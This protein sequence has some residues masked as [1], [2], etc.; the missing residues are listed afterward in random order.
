[1]KVRILEGPDPRQQRHVLSLKRSRVVTQRTGRLAVPNPGLP[2]TFPR[3]VLLAVAGLSPQVVTET[4][5]ALSQK[6]TPAFVPTEVHLFTTAEGAE[7][8][9]L[10]LL[11]DHPGWFASLRKDYGLPE[12]YFSE[13]TVH[14]L[15]TLSGVPLQDIRTR[16]ENERV[17]DLL[18]EKIRELTSDESCALH[19]SLAGGR[20]TMGFYAGY[21]LSLFGRPQDR[22]SHVLVSPPYESN[23]QFFYPTPERHV[24]F[25]PPPESRPLDTRQAQIELAEIPFVRLRPGLDERLLDG[26][27][28]FSEVVAAAQ[29][30]LDT[31][32]LRIDLDQ[33]CIFAGDQEVHVPPV[34]L[35]FLSWLARRAI[36]GEPFVRCPNDES[37]EQRHAEEYL[38]EYAHLGDDR[39]SITARRLRDEKGMT[40]AFFMETKSRLHSTLKKALGPEG[41]QSYG[42]VAE[43]QRGS[44]QY[45]IAVPAR[46]IHWLGEI[47]LS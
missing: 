39:E 42:V 18:T 12:I 24:I 28:R 31:P 16:E 33:K 2:H 4:I 7:R 25:T 34:Q 5:Y 19:L 36:L 45:R 20:K 27:A 14:V 22:L 3:R 21:A 43:G 29:R 26:T 37:P 13:E 23:P 40:K 15:K 6:S 46:N 17:A 1:M 30:A 41:V 47:E 35:A 10:M 32:V 9:R 44:Y 11:S 8:A 38:R